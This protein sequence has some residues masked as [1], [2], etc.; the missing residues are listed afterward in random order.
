M[1][2]FHFSAP[3]VLDILRDEFKHQQIPKCNRCLYIVPLLAII[4]TLKLELTKLGIDFQVLDSESR[5]E[6]KDHSKV[7][8]VTPEK[9]VCKATLKSITGLPWSAIVI[10]EPQYILSWGLSKKKKNGGYKK[11]F[12][13]AFQQLNR[14]NSLGA[15]FELHTATAS[16]LEKLFKLLGRKDSKWKKQ[17]VVPERENLT[18]YIVDGKNITDIKQFPFVTKF[19]EE[20]H[21][22]S[23]LIYV[24]KLEEG[25]KI[26]CS[27]NEYANENGLTTWPS[28]SERPVKPVAFL[29]ANLTEDRKEEII[30]EVLDC[31]VKV[32]VATSS[33]GAGVNLPFSALLGW[34][35]HPEPDGL[36][37]ASGRVGRK[38]LVEKGDV[39]WVSFVSHFI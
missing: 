16:N 38:P 12:R 8:I 23:L 7:V 20:T 33:V 26:F 31:K 37:Q 24:H 17:I 39:I 34:G 13:E 15:P 36:V 5:G 1:N 30:K 32:L 19:L 21:V 11:P 18:Y 9:L 35:L 22:G 14:L 29:N 2:F 10:D 3:D 4:S 25:S 28:R 6:I 27:L